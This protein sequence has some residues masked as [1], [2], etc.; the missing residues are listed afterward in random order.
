VES[1]RCPKSLVPENLVCQAFAA[2][3]VYKM[4]GLRSASNDELIGV[5]YAN[6]DT[7]EHNILAYLIR[8]TEFSR[9]FS[10]IRCLKLTFSL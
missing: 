6:T 3:E 9:S 5:R 8:Y 1:E 7:G 4:G 10:G 2:R